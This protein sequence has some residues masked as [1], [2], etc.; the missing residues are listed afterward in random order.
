LIITFFVSS[1]L[2]LKKL[3]VLDLEDLEDLED[4]SQLG[5]GWWIPEASITPDT[6]SVSRTSLQRL[7]ITE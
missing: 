4:P 6:S 5:S 2:G 3:P 7:F 1:L